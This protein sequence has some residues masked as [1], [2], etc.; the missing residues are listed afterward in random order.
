VGTL[1]EVRRLDEATHV[2]PFATNELALPIKPIQA[3]D[4]QIRRHKRIAVQA[5][6]SVQHP[7][8]AWT[9][10]SATCCIQETPVGIEEAEL[11]SPAVGDDNA[12]VGKLERR[13]H[14][15][16]EKFVGTLS[17]TNGKDRFGRHSPDRDGGLRARILDD[18]DPSAIADLNE[19]LR[20]FTPTAGDKNE[21]E[22][23]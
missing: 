6:H 23:G 12:T 1:V 19:M 17:K 13:G 21:G 8:L 14:A 18:R 11:G 15:I 16:E 9:L 20:T 4:R 5:R 10:A 3:A 7:Q 22:H 2:Q